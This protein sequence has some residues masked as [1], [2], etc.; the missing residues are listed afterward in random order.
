MQA[1]TVAFLG[2]AGGGAVLILAAVLG[3]LTPEQRAA[4]VEA[5]QRQIAESK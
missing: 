5:L 3:Q 2:T 4:L 1:V